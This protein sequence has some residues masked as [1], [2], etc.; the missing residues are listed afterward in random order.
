MVARSFLTLLMFSLFLSGCLPGAKPPYLVELYTLDYPHPFMD[1]V[2]LDQPIKVGRFSVAQSYNSAAMFYKTEPHKVAARVYHKW[3]INPGDMVTD[4]LL[5]DF[6]GSGLFP[7]VFSY[8]DPEGTRFIVDGGVEELLQSREGD[9]WK[10]VLS[11]QVTLLDTGQTDITKRLVFQKRYRV[12]ERIPDGSPES[13]ASGASGAMA[14]LSEEI[15]RD[16]YK[17]L[18]QR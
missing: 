10:A 18:T 15:M 7:A 2:T 14:G 13:F 16:V 1:G 6:R 3:R 5:R 9:G 11:L 17:A 12:A 4:Y 8:R